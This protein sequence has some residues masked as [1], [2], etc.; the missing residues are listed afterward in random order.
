[1]NL[2]FEIGFEEPWFLLLLV[3]LP[4]LWFFSFHSL[5]GLGRGRRFLS[6][7]FRSLVVVLI[8]FA[9]AKAKW[10]VKTDRLT[11]IYLL[12]Q[13]E[14]IP[15]VKREAMVQYVISEVEQRRREDKEDKA[16]VIVFG[17]NAKIESAPHDGN[18]PLIGKIESNVDLDTSTTSIESALKLAKASFP[19]DT[20]RRV[21]IVS[22]GNEN[23][24]DSLSL[25]EAMADDGIGIDVFPI[26]LLAR[27][28]VSVDK[29]VI[30]SDIRRGQKF[31]TKVVLTNEVKDED[32]SAGEVSGKL[33][34]TRKT[35]QSE[36]LVAE[37]AIKLKPGKNI[38]GFNSELDRSAVYTT[39]AVFVP[40][41]PTQDLIPQ[42][43]RASAFTQV[44]GKGKVLLVEDAFAP[45]EF[46]NLV[47]RLQA[48]SIEV[49]TINTANLF[50]T[51][52]ELLQYDSVILANVPRSS[53]DDTGTITSFSDAQIKMMVDNCEF[54]G[55]GIVMIGGDRAYGAGGWSNSLLEK[56]MPVDFQI[57]NDKI[58]AV[59]AL[60]MMMHASEM[61]NGNFWQVKIG[62]EALKVLG[63]MDYCGVIEWSDWG[64]NPRWMWKWPMAVDRVFNNRNRMLGL[65]NRMVP[66]DMP[67][68][69][70]P[71]KV[72]LN[73]L[74]RVKASMKHVI[75]ISDGDPTPPTAA[76]LNQFVQ[77]KI[78]ISTVA[79]GTHGPAGSTPLQKIANRTGGT[80]YVAKNP[81]ALPK[82]YQ[83]EARRVAK[84]VIKE[85]ESGMS[86]VEVPGAAGH[87]I[88]KGLDVTSLPVFR[89][90][91]MTTRKKSN[92]V[93]QLALASEPSND[94]GENSTLLATWRYGNGR[95]VAFTSD[96]GYRW[97]GTW[98][99]TDQYDKLFVQMVRY[100]MRPITQNANFSVS[101]EARDGIAKI[102][103]TALDEN[104]EFLDFLEMGGRGINSNS[105]DEQT[106]GITLDFVQVGPGRYEASHPIE[107]SGNFLYTIFPGEGYERLSTGIN[108][109]YSS[110]YTDRDSNLPLLESLSQFQP[111][112]GKRGE[113]ITVDEDLLERQKEI[114]QRRSAG[115]PVSDDD[116]DTLKY[117]PFQTNTFRPT[118]TTALNIADMWPYLVLLCGV[119]FFSD[120]F[121][122]RVSS[123]PV[124]IIVSFLVCAALLT[125]ISYGLARIAALFVDEN[126]SATA[127]EELSS[128]ML[129]L[130]I[131]LA[132]FGSFFLSFALSSDWV[133]KKIKLIRNR[134]TNSD[135]AQIRSSL[136]RLQSRKQEIEQEIESRRAAT[137]FEPQAD[138]R[139][140]GRQKLE[141]VIASEIE[142]TPA[143]PPKIDRSRV[144]TEEE[145]SYTSRLLDAKKK[146]QKK[147]ERESRRNQNDGD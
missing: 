78:K 20:A 40:D 19:E 145:A 69:N 74:K 112:D 17:G 51:P 85:S 130:A 14:S 60:A 97:T 90:Y 30:P 101:A 134:F 80:Y 32:G 62:E 36:E 81:K 102:V 26:Q 44:R 93:R 119:F 125:P 66:G 65:I 142:K 61:A 124:A 10:E 16:G 70:A 83:R 118:L 33:R 110:E 21:V 108:V 114:V 94:G 56:A 136:S 84:P 11:V 115:R 129:W 58:Q 67:D 139:V 98:Y 88:L 82:I 9:L 131:A 113:I 79:V 29:V 55:C 96:A 42:N 132:F 147:R 141:D 6:L 2:G 106:Q 18:L 68:F 46:N 50:T 104:E 105:S 28:E 71:M 47:E 38:I 120:V 73:G 133:L 7:F 53:G 95:T 49:D 103:V 22:D 63:P 31:E 54:M 126:T 146:I 59:G 1:M 116:L 143:L 8:V 76:L 72:M 109:P 111:A 25:A 15:L 39:D 24:G 23:I 135:D 128:A 45:G 77:A 5:A 4:L 99:N 43:N 64:G 140:S 13:S 121:V 122:R 37:Q 52:A 137:K 138:D 34:L 41:D 100:S 12:D 144:G 48:N 57:K 3:I 117:S 91:V 92:L 86:A 75:I 107:G 27:S 123:S 87:E 89:G 127:I 35:A